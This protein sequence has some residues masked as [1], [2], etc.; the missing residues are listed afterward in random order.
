MLKQYATLFL[1]T[2]CLP[3]SLH[4]ALEANG[5]NTFDNTPL[6]VFSNRSA[7]IA[8]T[9]HVTRITSDLPLN[10]DDEKKVFTPH[11]VPTIQESKLS[12]KER[13]IAYYRDINGKKGI[14]F[15]KYI[16]KQ[17]NDRKSI[18]CNVIMK[19]IKK[20]LYK[21][22]PQLTKEVFTK[23]EWGE[24]CR[25][26][27]VLPFLF[28]D[29]AEKKAKKAQK[30]SPASVLQFFVQNFPELE[31][32]AQDDQ[33]KYATD[34]IQLTICFDV[35]E[36]LEI[37]NNLIT[38][39]KKA[40]SKAYSATLSDMILEKILCYSH[41]IF[42]ELEIL[43]I[44]EN[45]PVDLVL[46]IL[47]AKINKTGYSNRQINDIFLRRTYNKVTKDASGNMIQRERVFDHLLRKVLFDP[48]RL[49]K[50]LTESQKVLLP[51]SSSKIIVS[52][53][54]PFIMKH[55]EP[56]YMQLAYKRT[57]LLM[58][59]ARNVALV[60][61]GVPSLCLARLKMFV[62]PMVDTSFVKSVKFQELLLNAY[63]LSERYKS[64]IFLL[65]E[66]IKEYKRYVNV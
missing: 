7:G 3:K 32:S 22:D 39:L 61:Q 31:W 64:F 44:L 8:K 2:L 34:H 19:M 57:L 16:S 24:A 37:I 30:C 1:I 9:L 35:E 15:E 63:T 50:P 52:K 14:Q 17:G 56:I 60:K 42:D 21:H 65:I 59:Y 49:C 28:R 26:S 12:S 43:K 66:N 11:Q 62:W 5:Q 41:S 55:I 20:Q 53:K 33:G 25:L 23:K 54:A 36:H 58:G 48:L 13:L 45:S 4:S 46:F 18:Y 38:I 47:K 6:E 10:Q 27:E 40:K 51:H 29:L